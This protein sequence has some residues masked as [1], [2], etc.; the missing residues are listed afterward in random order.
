MV[1]VSIHELDLVGCAKCTSGVEDCFS[2]ATVMRD[3]VMRDL[4]P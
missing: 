3:S 1:M 4:E 2:T